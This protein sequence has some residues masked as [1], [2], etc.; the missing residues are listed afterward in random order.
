MDCVRT[1]RVDKVL[2]HS[3]RARA[4]LVV[5]VGLHAQEQKRHAAQEREREKK[6]ER[7]GTG[8]FSTIGFCKQRARLDVQAIGEDFAEGGERAQDLIVLLHRHGVVEV[9]KILDQRV[10]RLQ[11]EREK[12]REKST[13]HMT[14]ARAGRVCC[15]AHRQNE[16]K[17]RAEAEAVVA[18]RRLHHGTQALRHQHS[19]PEKNGEGKQQSVMV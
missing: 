5:L 1:R 4:R 6:K 15:T 16:V 13:S 17:V 12:E 19:M 10:Q 3:E 14:E 2:Q 8:N 9:W 18:H 11:V 7:G